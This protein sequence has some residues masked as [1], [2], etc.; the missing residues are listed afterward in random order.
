MSGFKKIN[1]TPWHITYIGLKDGD[2]PRHKS[3]CINYNDTYCLKKHR[4]CT[5]SAHCNSYREALKDDASRKAQSQSKTK[6]PIKQPE[7]KST[8]DRKIASFKDG[9]RVFHEKYGYGKI[10]KI[11]GELV[12]I[13][14][15]EV[16]L[17][18]LGLRACV[19][20]KV[21]SHPGKAFYY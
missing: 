9:D 21:L 8:I 18:V 15:D 16:G 2:V 3:R 11:E 4:K 10:F 5:G 20:N 6:K 7:Y 13:V 1:G 12:H 19:V 17:R 14:F